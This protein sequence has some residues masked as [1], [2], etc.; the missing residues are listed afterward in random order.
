MH[1]KI[2]ISDF[3][4]VAT[5]NAID[6]KYGFVTMMLSFSKRTVR[7]IEFTTHIFIP[8]KKVAI[9]A[10]GFNSTLA[11]LSKRTEVPT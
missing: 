1:N 3:F 5:K 8:Q 11:A 6:L 9:K 4:C 7:G 2:K 10:H